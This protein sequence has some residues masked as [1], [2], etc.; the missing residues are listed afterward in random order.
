MPIPRRGDPVAAGISA[1]DRQEQDL[2]NR[3]RRN[4]AAREQ[5][6]REREGLASSGPP[7]GGRFGGG[8]P[9]AV[10]TPPAGERQLFGQTTSSFSPF[11]DR[12]KGEEVSATA[13]TKPIPVEIKRAPTGATGV[14]SITDRSKAKSTFEA[15]TKSGLDPQYAKKLAIK[16]GGGMLEEEQSKIPFQAG[17]QEVQ[18]VFVVNLTEMGDMMISAVSQ[19]Q[20]ATNKVVSQP[21]SS[22]TVQDQRPN[23]NLESAS[24]AF[25]GGLQEGFSNITGALTSPLENV[26]GQF[27]TSFDNIVT[28]FA[29]IQG[30][31][32]GLL[33]SINNMTVNHTVSVE[34]LINIG[35]L[36]IESIKTELSSSIGRVVA[37]EVQ[38][39]M[40]ERGRGFDAG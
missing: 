33:Q 16:A 5:R 21:S 17:G 11:S 8:I 3:R 10:G 38:R 13:T 27:S 36:N 22:T 2:A 40:N 20:Q 1:K 7:S 26:V 18:N 23:P 24:S 32:D 29:G 4:I 25:I 19:M 14:A 35:G 31:L 9:G 30:S 15:A 6:K 12:P 28:A 37:D 39:S 34:G